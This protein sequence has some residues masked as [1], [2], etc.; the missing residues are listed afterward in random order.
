MRLKGS[1]IFL[2]T[3]KRLENVLKAY[4]LCICFVYVGK[5]FCVAPV[6]LDVL[7]SWP[8]RWV[9]CLQCWSK[10]VYKV[11]LKVLWEL[12]WLV[13]HGF[14]G[15]IENMFSK[16]IFISMRI[17]NLVFQVLGIFSPLYYKNQGFPMVFEWKA[18]N[19]HFMI[20][21]HITE[22]V[23]LLIAKLLVPCRWTY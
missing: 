15:F 19:S 4:M 14:E 17:F 1:C 20:W 9:L 5:C 16:L 8:C 18:E 2:P 22:C 13:F 21:F 11:I 23:I 10:G 3:L 12:V 6:F 7:Y